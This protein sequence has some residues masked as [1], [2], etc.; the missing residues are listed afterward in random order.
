MIDDCILNYSFLPLFSGWDGKLVKEVPGA[1]KADEY[2][3]VVVSGAPD[4]VEGQV[5]EVEEV[6]S[7]TGLAQAD[8]VWT[9]L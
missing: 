4:H 2:L 3:A 5:I 6:S 7:S 9:V 8:T 1:Q